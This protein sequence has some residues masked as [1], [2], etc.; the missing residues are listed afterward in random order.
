M[1]KKSVTAKYK[2]VTDNT[3]PSTTPDGSTPAN[4]NGNATMEVAKT[5]AAMWAN[6]NQVPAANTA[7]VRLRHRATAEAIAPNASWPSTTTKTA[8]SERNQFRT[9][10]ANHR[11]RT[12][13]RNT[14]S[15]LPGAGLLAGEIAAPKKS[16]ARHP[17]VEASVTATRRKFSPARESTRGFDGRLSLDFSPSRKY[18]SNALIV[19]ARANEPRTIHPTASP[20]IRTRTASSRR[21]L[22]PCKMWANAS[23]MSLGR[24]VRNSSKSPL[25]TGRVCKY[26]ETENTNA[27]QQAAPKLQRQ[28]ISAS[29]NAGCRNT[30]NPSSV[31][32]PDFMS[33]KL[34][35][36][37]PPATSLILITRNSRVTIHSATARLLHASY[38]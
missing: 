2:S 38:E 35:Q 33:H 13:L 28:A 24:S 7:P 11:S 18:V 12:T 8:A 15:A 1:Y 19:A 16:A 22:L 32:E 23:E 5:N 36:E 25:L 27:R 17:T 3:P 30:R 29:P 20:E 9:D 6:P 31:G 34:S 4:A 21:N 10:Q 37:Q 14:S 26:S